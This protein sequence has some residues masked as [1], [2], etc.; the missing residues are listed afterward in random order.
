MRLAVLRG[1]GRERSS[2]LY[3]RKW[4]SSFGWSVCVL[5]EENNFISW[6]HKKT[7]SFY[8][9]FHF[10]SSS[11]SLILSPLYSS[12]IS[13]SHPFHHIPVSSIIQLFSFPQILIE[14]PFLPHLISLHLQILHTSYFHSAE[15]ENYEPFRCIQRAE[16]EFGKAIFDFQELSTEDKGGLE[17]MKYRV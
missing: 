9:H 13:F 1:E 15:F 14:L 10:I 2:R 4:D 17:A 6:N 12:S 3:F 7:S 16:S 11:T 5:D 8:L